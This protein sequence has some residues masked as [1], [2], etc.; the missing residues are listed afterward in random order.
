M[1]TLPL[2]LLLAT[3]CGSGAS[4]AGADSTAA[5]DT[6]TRRQKDSITAQS[7]IPGARGVGQA[8]EAQDTAAARQK[9]IDSIANAP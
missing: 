1:R 8:L 7:E 2:V 3:A 4:S 9:T 5:R 6:L